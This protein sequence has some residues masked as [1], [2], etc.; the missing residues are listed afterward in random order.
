MPKIVSPIC[1][2]QVKSHS[3]TLFLKRFF[4]SECNFLKNYV[5]V[6]H[7]HELLRSVK[8]HQSL[9]V[10]WHQQFALN[11]ISTP[12]GQLTQN[13]VGSIGGGATCSSNVAKIFLIG[14]IDG[15]HGGQLEN[16]F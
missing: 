15:R 8:V 1:N 3:N 4:F 10:V 2:K 14:N 5:S 12:L 6:I 13:L 16:L 7:A 11:D 9:S